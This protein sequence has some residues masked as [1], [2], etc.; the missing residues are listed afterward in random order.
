MKFERILIYS[1]WMLV[2]SD[3][4]LSAT[5]T[6]PTISWDEVIGDDLWYLHSSDNPVTEIKLF[7]CPSN[8]VCQMEDGEFAF[9]SSKYQEYTDTSG[10]T[11]SNSQIYFKDTKYYCR[12]AGEF[13]YSLNNGQ[14]C[15]EH[16][17]CVSHYCL[18]SKCK[19]FAS[20]KGCSYHSDWAA[21][22]ACI[23]DSSFPYA[24]TW[25]TWL[26]SGSWVDDYDCDPSYFCWYVDAAAVSSSSKTCLEKFSQADGTTFGWVTE[27]DDPAFDGLLNGKYCSSGFAYESTTD[28]A[29][30]ASITQVSSDLG[31]QTTPYACTATDTTNTCDYYYDSTNFVS[32]QWQWAFDGTDGYWPIPGQD[33]LTT[34]VTY[35]KNFDAVNNC[36]TLDRNNYRRLMNSCAVTDL[37]TEEYWT[38]AADYYFQMNYWP[39]LQGDSAS[40]WMQEV[41]YLSVSNLIKERAMAVYIT[42]LFTIIYLAFL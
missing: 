2:L 18:N 13:D 32:S 16:Y 15:S 31:V 3:W 25:Q 36:H 29:T 33:E 28:T 20:G 8:E 4:I 30:C 17:Q 38:N 24:T 39:Y 22:L 35:M 23:A 6:C 11:T 19:G 10:N 26:T 9:V 42:S 40:E 21:G 1:I 37:E 12:N 14:P 27:E 41:F 34:Y 5:I 7:K